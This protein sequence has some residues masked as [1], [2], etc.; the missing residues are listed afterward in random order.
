MSRVK[1][2]GLNR[3]KNDIVTEQIR[4]VLGPH[5]LKDL[6]LRS[7]ESMKQLRELNIF[8]HVDLK[9]DVDKSGG[10]AEESLEVTF[11]VEEHGWLKS[12]VAAHAGTQSGDAVSMDFSTFEPR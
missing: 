2:A 3:T 10:R 9:I 4:Q 6:F 5:S 11:I 12:T 8:K 1:V 7:L